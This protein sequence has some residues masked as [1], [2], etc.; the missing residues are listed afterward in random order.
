MLTLK[1]GVTT[2][3]STGGKLLSNM[4]SMT[5]GEIKEA[6]CTLGLATEEDREALRFVAWQQSQPG[7]TISLTERTEA[8]EGPALP[9][10]DA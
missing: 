9:S 3:E 4:Q 1:R 6:F 2:D 8:L 10:A 5:E 7:I